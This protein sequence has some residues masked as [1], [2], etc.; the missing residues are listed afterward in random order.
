[1]E[2]CPFRSTYTTRWITFE[3]FRHPGLAPVTTS[4]V[5]AAFLAADQKVVHVLNREC[6]TRSCHLKTQAYYTKQLQ[7][8]TNN[9]LFRASIQYVRLRANDRNPARRARQW[10]KCV[11]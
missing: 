3:K 8:W 7:Q 2:M 9:H 11:S 6:E 5:H 4:H 1:M 10:S